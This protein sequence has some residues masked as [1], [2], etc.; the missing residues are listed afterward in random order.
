MNEK[1]TLFKNNFKF[2]KKYGQNF[3]FDKNL[4]KAIIND[5]KISASDDVLEIGKK[6][7]EAPAAPT[8]KKC[9]YC[10][11]EID[12]NATRCPHCTSVLEEK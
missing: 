8:T 2:S 5:S 10:M 3:I 6:V 7:E 11:S 4:L 12:I 9:N 1:E